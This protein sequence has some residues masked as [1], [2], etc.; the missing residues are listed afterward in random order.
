MSERTVAEIGASFGGTVDGGAVPGR[1]STLAGSCTTRSSR[2]PECGA[3]PVEAIGERVHGGAL[4]GELA[5]AGIDPR[6]VLD[7]SVNVNP[8]GPCPA[9]VA[10][11]RAAPVHLYPDPKATLVREAIATRS[12]TPVEGV[13]FGSGAADLLWTLARV[14]LANG[15]RALVV[16]PAFSE[17]RAA[18]VAAGANI[19][20]WRANPEHGLAVDLQAVGH[21]AACASV[22]AVYLCA[23]T[24]PAGVAVPLAGV[25]VL[26]S[27]LPDSLVIV[28]ES[29]L[30][31]SDQSAEAGLALPR[32]VARLRSLTKEHAIPGLRAGYL[33]APP[34]LARAM[35]AN[36][37]PWSTSSLAQ[38]AALA[39][40]DAEG[41]VATSRQRLRE[42]REAT[43]GHLSA[44]G[45]PPI[46]SVAPYL[47][48]RTED[49]AGLRR[50]LLAHRILVRD[51]DSFGLVGFLRIAARP[52]AERERLAAALAREL[53]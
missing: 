6:E 22:D 17:F 11:I 51:C 1:E 48:F 47:V 39:A 24:T 33:L 7:F 14:L 37:P 29:F 18:A 27:H 21:M 42:D 10:A 3:S 34:A 12:G 45:H 9:V 28:D 26:A 32:N 13:V 38:A 53:P 43:A 44:L 5:A 20:A 8:Y 19:W 49:A 36:R 46:P 16:E 50:R 15:G 41:F 23:P 30:S 4:A 52:L 2:T 25:A 35:E 31:L 40:L